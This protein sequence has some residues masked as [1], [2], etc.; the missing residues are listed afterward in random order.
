MRHVP[1]GQLRRLVDEPFAVPDGA[2]AHLSRCRRCTRR[3]EEVARDA[4]AAAPLFARLG[5]PPA[6]SFGPAAELDRAWARF[7]HAAPEARGRLAPR[8]KVPRRR[9]R[10]AVP[11][12]PT[13]AL[14]TAAVLLAGAGAATAIT[15][16]LSPGR[17]KPVQV[18]SSDFQ[19]LAKVVGLDG[20]SGL[21]GSL[22]RPSGTVHLPFGV[23]HWSSSPAHRVASVAAARGETGLAA[24]SVTRHP[25]G[26]GGVRRVVVQPRVTATID[27]AGGAAA[28]VRGAT[29]T[30]RAGPAVAVE[31][32][33]AATGL[34]PPLATFVMAP[35][36]VTSTKV[37]VSRLEEYLL[38]RR[39]L[40]AHLVHEVRLL[41]QLGTVLPVTAPPGTRASTVRVDGTRGVLLTGVKGVESAAS[42]VVWEEH[43][44]IR[45]AL[46]LL[47]RSDILSVA[48]Q[49]G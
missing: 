5:S 49:L 12:P 23:L 26:V 2:A 32:S 6:G 18:S 3:S 41:R 22:G 11:M 19:T 45:A 47:D 15:S 20:G 28:S 13:A 33:G 36:V 17:A 14:V 30:L 7:G 9:W 38:S 31:Y 48:G 4:A 1:D 10:L 42:A 16:A 43:G 25:A 40:P 37:S 8:L 35:P 27:F 39:G 46:G 21:T 29:L 34:V 24:G 44:T